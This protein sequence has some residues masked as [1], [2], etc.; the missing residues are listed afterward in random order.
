MTSIFRR[1]VQE[2]VAQH[3]DP[4]ADKEIEK[5]PAERVT[6]YTYIPTKRKW[7]KDISLIKM[8]ALPFDEG[9][10]RQVYRMKKISQAPTAKWK[11]DPLD[12]RKAPNYVVKCYKTSDGS[13]NINNDR[14]K[15]FLDVK[16]Q[17]EA[18]YWASQFNK[19]GPPK[20]IKVIQCNVLELMDR[21]GS[22]VVGCERYVDGHDKCGA[23][24]VKHNSNSGYVD[25][26]QSRSTPQAFSAHSF[27]ESQG[28]L[29]V[30]DIQGVGDLY[31]DPQVHSQD[32]RFGDSDLGVRGMALFFVSFRRN[33]VCDALLLPRFPLSTRERNRIQSGSHAGS[34]SRMTGLR[35]DISDTVYAKIE[36]T[37]TKGDLK[38]LERILADNPKF[39]ALSLDEQRQHITLSEK[40]LLEVEAA[41]LAAHNEA[42]KVHDAL[43]TKG[44]V[45][46]NAITVENNE[47]FIYSQFSLFKQAY[48][49]TWKIGLQKAT[50]EVHL[51]I[52]ILEA[53]GRFSS[54]EGNKYHD[55]A[56]VASCLFH[57]CEASMLGSCAAALALGRLRAGLGSDLLEVLGD[58]VAEDRGAALYFYEL[59]AVRGSVMGAWQAAQIF[60]SD[61]DADKALF[62]YELILVLMGLR[63]NDSTDFETNNE[64][65]SFSVGDIV[66]GNY[67]GCGTWYE[68]SV[69]E[70]IRNPHEEIA[71]YIQYIDDG[72]KETVSSDL[73]RPSS[74]KREFSGDRTY[75]ENESSVMPSDFEAWDALSQ[76]EYASI[77]GS[78]G[79]VPK[80][81]IGDDGT[82]VPALFEVY[83]ALA[84]LNSSLGNNDSAWQYFNDA[85]QSAM[86]AGKP[87]LANNYL[88]SAS[89]YE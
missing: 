50:G 37:S 74:V 31:T 8:E 49:P 66:E 52:A 38:N 82:F 22:P 61:G 6:R 25:E 72:E 71:Y 46:Y 9:A 60:G 28:K 41:I 21:E 14:E 88:E 79:F 12:W 1:L 78:K 40:D 20:H 62:M 30:V 54:G 43:W 81:S 86:D 56:D 16:I 85:A 34:I 42:V 70:V 17:Y 24:F 39:S 11:K 26:N 57:L 48:S 75:D 83:A 65:Q 84:E 47:A 5:L 58:Y 51:E 55:V 64:D 3:V 33:P 27:Y 18:S 19:A 10:Q 80:K 73:I 59:A 68:A 87:K 15:C 7:Q 69:L 35:E 53:A 29:M 2:A 13:I 32:S 45:P 77:K 76:S 89:M 44:Y 67:C 23:G 63:R 4:W 36:S